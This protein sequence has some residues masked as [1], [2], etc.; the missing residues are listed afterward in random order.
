MAFD[1]DLVQTALLRV[2]LVATVWAAFIVGFGIRYSLRDAGW[3]R[4]SVRL[5]TIATWVVAI[6]IPS[7]LLLLPT[8]GDDGRLFLYRVLFA[9]AVPVFVLYGLALGPIR[10]AIERR[11]SRRIE[12]FRAIRSAF[13]EASLAETAADREHLDQSLADLDRF[14]EPATFEYV[15][16]ARS[17]IVSWLDGGPR[18]ESREGRW[19]AR[20]IELSDE[21]RP[22]SWRSDRLSITARQTYERLISRTPLLAAA[23]GLVLGRS[24]LAGPV[25][26]A[27]PAAIVGGYLLT[28][29]WSLAAAPAWGGA[30]IG[31]GAATVIQLA[32]RRPETLLSAGLLTAALAGL[33]AI[34]A[35]GARR[36]VALSVVDGGPTSPA[37]PTRPRAG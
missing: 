22:A 16:L 3:P 23:A 34:E 32:D 8:D 17:R 9:A 27:M 29:R 7:R 14:I 18:A 1:W 37:S 10:D 35:F 4:W 25:A 12:L 30:A 33:A 20:M 11:P 19:S 21:L 15:Q 31:L 2:G 6:L 26:L 24:V 5:L 28:W 36:R 13:E